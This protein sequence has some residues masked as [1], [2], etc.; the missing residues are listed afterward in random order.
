M[1]DLNKLI[2]FQG[3]SEECELFNCDTILHLI[4]QELRQ[5]KCKCFTCSPCAIDEGAIDEGELTMT[6]ACLISKNRKLV[7]AGAASKPSELQ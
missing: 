1:F 5:K 3:N 2:S 6:Q 4:E 7:S